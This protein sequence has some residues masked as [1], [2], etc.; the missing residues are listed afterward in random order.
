MNF[1]K[2]IKEAEKRKIDQS[3]YFWKADNSS[4]RKDFWKKDTLKHTI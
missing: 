2:E 1:S 4:A 3:L